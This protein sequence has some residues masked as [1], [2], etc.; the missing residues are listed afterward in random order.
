MVKD[1]LKISIR[2]GNF[3]SVIILLHRNLYSMMRNGET[4]PFHM[5]GALNC[6]L[7]PPVLRVPA[8]AHCGA[9]PDGTGRL[10]RYPLQQRAKMCTSILMAYIS[11]AKSGSMIITLAYGLMD[12]VLSAMIS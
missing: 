9:A 11:T 10:L 5:I 3:F 6:L 2:T 7:T 1:K 4:C 12:L 8:V